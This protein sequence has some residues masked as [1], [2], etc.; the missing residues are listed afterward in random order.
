MPNSK[1]AKERLKTNERNRSRNVAV[2]SR[3]KTQVGKAQTA[4]EGKDPAAVDAALKA[5]LSEIDRAASKGVLHPKSAGR[6][7]SSLQRRAAKLLASK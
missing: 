2:R 3:M 1:T 7:K 5:A 4:L 6:K